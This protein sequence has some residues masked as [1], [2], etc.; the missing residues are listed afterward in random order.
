MPHSNRLHFYFCY[1]LRAEDTTR[2]RP[3]KIKDRMA[4]LPEATTEL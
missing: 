2:Q 3:R 4:V 1:L